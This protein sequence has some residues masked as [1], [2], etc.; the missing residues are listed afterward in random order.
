MKLA[1]MAFMNAVNM[2]EQSSSCSRKHFLQI[3]SAGLTYWLVGGVALS[4]SEFLQ[5]C[6]KGDMMGMDNQSMTM[7]SPVFVIEGQFNTP[8][9][10]IQDFNAVMVLQ[11]QAT[12]TT[13]NGITTQVL[14]YSPFSLLGPAFN[15]LQGDLISIPITNELGETTNVHWH[16]LHIESSMDGLPNIGIESGSSFTASF[17]IAQRA[18]MCW[19]HPHFD[20]NTASQ[21]WKGLA[22]I[23][24]I[25]DQEESVLSL[26]IGEF[27]IPL[28]IQD[29]NIGET[30]LIYNPSGMDVMFGLQG[31]SIVVN[32][33]FSPFLNVSK[34]AYR[35]R[36]LNGSNARIFNLAFS[37]NR[38][39]LVI[40]N[41]GGLLPQSVNVNSAFLA[42][43]ERLDML[44]DFSS[45]NMG[46]EVFLKNLSFAG[47]GSTQ[48]AQEY[49]ILK[50]KVNSENSANNSVSNTFSNIEAYSQSGGSTRVFD[51]SNQNMTM[52]MNHTINGLAYSSDV[53]NFIVP[54]SI[55]ETWVFDNSNGAESHPMHVHGTSFQVIQRI[56][57]RSSI[58]PYE[59]GWK[60]TV[61]VMPGEKVSVMIRFNTPNQKYVLHCHNLEHEDNGMMLQ[62]EVQ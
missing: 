13:L 27:E 6:S 44:V 48:G 45:A 32:G 8:L 53:I 43:G 61:L 50:F 31:S 35:L 24:F 60:D 30:G 51:I 49:S 57:G 34:S 54:N 23:F 9:I 12:T 46:D 20:G 36:V 3:S 25:R 10:Q 2:S 40:G 11:P 7:G 14:G 62:F 1:T 42:P 33:V 19:Y 17:Q 56:G 18:S 39:F 47:G 4:A 22:G 41:D 37:D 16:G 5:S 28:V 52:S 15:F 29:K 59:S 55:V 58:M 26:P 21:V 38:S